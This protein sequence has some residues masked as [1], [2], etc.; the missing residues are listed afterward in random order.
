MHI[1][2][3]GSGPDLVLVHGWAMHGGV[4]AP[5]LERLAAHFRVH[6]VD[7]PGH[8]FARAEQH[9]DAQDSARRIAAE[10]PRAPW[11]GWSLGGQVVLHAALQSPTQVRGVALIASSPRFVRAADWPDAVGAEVFA[12]FAAELRLRYRHAIE[13]FLALETMGSPHAQAELRD[14]RQRVF[15]RGEPRMEALCDGLAALESG[16][17][18]AALPS[19]AMPSLWIAGRRDRLVPPAAMQRAAGLAAAGRYLEFNSG[20][21]PFIEHA[22]GVADALVEFER[23]LPA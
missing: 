6:V 9:F 20:H 16:D 11:V 12:E 10:T 15:A 2:T 19:L 22:D 17:L 13:R 3:Q 14:L 23:G 7:L 5:L 8:G 4:F 18:R 1:E 21:A